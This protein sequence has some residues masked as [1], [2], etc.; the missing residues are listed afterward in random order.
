MQIFDP[1]ELNDS[2]GAVRKHIFT[3]WSADYQTNS[4]AASPSVTF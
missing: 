1:L 3:F 4:L 2:S